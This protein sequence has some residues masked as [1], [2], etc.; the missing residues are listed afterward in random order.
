M[1]LTLSALDAVSG[2][3]EYEDMFRY[4][5][6]GLAGISH[7]Q[8][9]LL[10]N[11][12]IQWDL[13]GRQWLQEEDWDGNPDGY[14]QDWTAAQRARLEELNA[15][16][17]Q[18]RGPLSHLAEGLRDA[19]TAGGKMAALYAFLEEIGLPQ[20]LQDKTNWLRERGELQL[21]DEYRQIWELLCRIMDQFV[22]ILGD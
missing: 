22:E 16:R 13:H 1:P 21:A 5:K 9:D 11:Y 20:Q 4:L 7:A 14:S 18:V 19:E 6:T 15:I 17:S 12:A 10:E 2:G 8:C 3:Y